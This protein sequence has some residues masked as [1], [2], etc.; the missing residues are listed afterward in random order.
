MQDILKFNKL[1]SKETKLEHNY[2]SNATILFN[3]YLAVRFKRIT[4]KTIPTD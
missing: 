1:I 4:I 3:L 2:I